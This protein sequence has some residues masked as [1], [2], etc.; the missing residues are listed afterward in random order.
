M[1]SKGWGN[2]KD[3]Y[4]IELKDDAISFALT[5]PRRVP[6]PLLPKVKDKLQIWKEWES[7]RRLKSQASGVQG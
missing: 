7:S 3:S 4:K 1:Y 6:I 2:I 5:T